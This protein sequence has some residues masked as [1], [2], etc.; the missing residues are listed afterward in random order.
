M[1]QIERNMGGRTDQLTRRRTRYSQKA[2][3]IGNPAITGRTLEEV[4][5]SDAQPF[6]DA[7]DAAGSPSI[8][9]R[10]A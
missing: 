5:L 9:A 7:I 10:R 4:H 1:L 3:M 2:L 8:E 6:A